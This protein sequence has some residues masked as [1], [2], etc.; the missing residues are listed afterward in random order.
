MQVTDSASVS[1]TAALSLTIN[2]PALSITTSSL[3][4]G[5][6]GAPYS[7]ALAAAGG[8]PPYA[9]SL[10][11][12]A[13]PGGLTLGANGTISG[14]PLSSGPFSFSVQVTDSAG[15]KTTNTFAI[16]IQPPAVQITTSSLPAYT[17]GA[18]YTQ[19]LTAT[20]GTPPFTWSLGSGSLPPGLALDSGGTIRGT[21]TT[22]GSYTFS[23]RV[24]DRAGAS[25]TRGYA[26]TINGAVSIETNSL[27]D[28][29]IGAPYSQQLRADR[30]DA[31]LLVVVDVRCDAGRHHA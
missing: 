23:V 18:S 21:A 19:T 17:A 7:Q 5:S 14:T 3:P 25:A 24:T 1:A 28:A 4:A 30:R 11:S 20:G 6:V 15:I 31:A 10:S 26:I 9:W 16:Q 2:P 13:L 22:A 27:A 29:L 8:S 12:G